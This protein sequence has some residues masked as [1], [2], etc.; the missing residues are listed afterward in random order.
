MHGPVESGPSV[1]AGLPFVL[2]RQTALH[3]NL[4]EHRHHWLIRVHEHTLTP[5]IDLKPSLAGWADSRTGY[6]AYL[7]FTAEGADHFLVRWIQI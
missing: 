1:N 6:V 2:L 5:I 4:A 3:A 7:S